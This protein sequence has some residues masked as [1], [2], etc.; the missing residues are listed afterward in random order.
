MK[1]F[2]LLFCIAIITGSSIFSIAG[3]RAEVIIPGEHGPKFFKM[4]SNAKPGDFLP[5]TIIFKVKPQYRQNCKVNSID[6]ILPLRDMLESV[7]AQN[8]AKIYPSHRAPDH[9]FNELG[10]RLVDISLIYSFKYTASL[11]LEKAINKFIALGYFE[12]VEPWDIPKV[13]YVPNDPS[14][15]SQYHMQGNVVG[16]VDAQGAWNTT[17]GSSS[18]VIGIVDTGTQPTHPDLAANYLG[19]Y[20]VAMNDADPTWQG[21]THG[22]ETSGDADAVTDN[23]V[24]VSS[25]G[26][27]CK[28]KAVKIAD[29]TGT[30]TA[31]YPGITWAADNGCKIINCSWGGPYGGQYGQDIVDYA[32]I[33]KNCVVFCSAGNILGDTLEFPASFAN[34]YRVSSSDQQDRRSSF[35]SYGLDVDFCSPG[36]SIYSTT[37]GTGYSSASGTS[38]ACPVA[39]GVAGLVQSKFNYTNAFQIGERMKQTCD[40]L[41]ATSPT[42]T[43]FNQGMLGKGRVDAA[44]AVASTAAKS[45]AVNPVV[46]TDGGDNVFMPAE[47]ITISGTFINYLDP[48]SSS[49]AATLSVVSGG[50]AATVTQPNFTIGVLATLA[51]NNNNSTPFSVNISPAAPVN[52]VIKFKIHIT[53]GT[54][55]GDTYFEIT[56]NPDYINIVNNDV[57]TSITSRGRIG[58]NLDAEQQGLGF[59]YQIPTPSNL[60]YEM[61]LMIGTSSSKVSDMFRDS[62]SGNTDF[63][64]TTRVHEVTPATV[65]DFDVDGKFNDNPA[66]GS[67]L[68]VEVH[69]SAYAWSTSP[70]RKFVI[71]KYVIKNTTGATLSNLRAGIIAD[72]DITDAAKNHAK[73]DAANRMGYAYDVSVANGL[74]AGIK[75]LSAGTANNYVIDLAGSPV[76][77]GGVDASKDFTSTEKYTVLSTTRNTDGYINSTTGTSGDVMD[78]VSSGPFTI[79]AGD[80][81]TVA[82]ALIGGSNLADIQASACAAQNKYDNGCAVGVNDLEADNFWMYNY[83]NPAT[84]SFNIDYNVIGYDNASIRIMN[85]LGETVMAFENL[86]QGRN[87]LSIDASKLSSGNYFYQ[88][89]AGEAVMT[90]KLTIVK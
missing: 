2:S 50:S 25:P 12:Y 85:T 79:N 59:Q 80:S 44:K 67:K 17:K 58:W 63:G 14:I 31:G 20:D 81:I 51:T 76:G 27:N 10:Q 43:L 11:S 7:G 6:N 3:N 84:G 77:N 36:T 40:P 23:G 56:V 86:A 60:L 41:S 54:F 55:S 48:S 42:S 8:L 72:W 49:A 73:Y 9:E 18:V 74:Y 71:V 47:I 16:S 69:H 64:S 65:S 39:A 28:F 57:H 35:T 46:V 75:L 88:L 33:N 26:F 68:G 22:C 83:P 87:T 90:K 29:Q 82:W 13:D 32:A 37:S 4:P 30:L 89:K 78:C 62:T 24:G 70:Y 53:D 66:G 19:G 52:Q 61:S 45:L 38:M 5:N 21:N 34:T 1:K 15:G